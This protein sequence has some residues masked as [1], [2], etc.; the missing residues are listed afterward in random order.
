M[1]TTER[2][3]ETKINN[4]PQQNFSLFRINLIA[5]RMYLGITLLVY[6]NAI[7]C[8]ISFFELFRFN[9]HMKQCWTGA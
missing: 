5:E 1:L 7:K 2:A 3:T 6:A 8:F 4:F 9:E